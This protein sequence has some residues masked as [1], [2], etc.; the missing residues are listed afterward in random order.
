MTLSIWLAIISS[1][2]I[3]GMIS[4]RSYEVIFDKNLISEQK[5][6]SCDK[7]VLTFF[8]KNIKLLNRLSRK[9]KDVPEI[10]VHKVH[11]F[12]KVIS[13]KVDFLFEKIKR[14]K[15]DNNKGSVSIYWQKV[16]ESR[17]SEDSE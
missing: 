2:V 7:K 17:K 9:T 12:W 1:V 6:L 5:R 8:N 15:K 13:N 16:S 10:I 14:N 4:Y 3:I 11:D